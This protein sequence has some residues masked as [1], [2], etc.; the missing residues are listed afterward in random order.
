M[1]KEKRE[2]DVVLWGATGF[3]G[4]LTAEY[5]L[6]HYGVG[7]GLRWA[8]AGRNAGKLEELKRV[9]SQETGK[10]VESLPSLVGDSNDEGFLT[11]LAQSTEVVCTTVGPYAQYGTGLVKACA[12]E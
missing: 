11:G 6:E 3:T 1:D 2:Y 9:L 5:L 8:I 4:R 12:Q 7:E 10:S